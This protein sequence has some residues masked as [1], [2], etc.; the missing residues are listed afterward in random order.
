VTT[1]RKKAA[2]RARRRGPRLEAHAVDARGGAPSRPRPEAPEPVVEVAPDGLTVAP[3]TE[4]VVEAPAPVAAPLDPPAPAPA[5]EH[6]PD[7]LGI[8]SVATGVM[9]A[10]H[11]AEN[12]PLSLI[13][14]ANTQQPP[15]VEDLF[16]P[17]T[18][19]GSARVCQKRLIQ[20]VFSA[21]RRD[22]YL[23][24]PPGRAVLSADE[25][26]RLLGVIATQGTPACRSEQA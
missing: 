16:R 11:T 8:T 7:G 20:R 19:N 17:A 10:E 5:P 26:D 13:V 1:P 3:P 2:P 22:D 25:A 21:N 23:L 18:P 14:D 6:A 24:L 12:V 9:L 4:P 15:V